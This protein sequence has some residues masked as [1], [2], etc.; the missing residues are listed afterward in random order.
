MRLSWVLLPLLAAAS[1]AACNPNK[2]NEAEGTR[3]SEVSS[4]APSASAAEA[5]KEKPK[6]ATLQGGVVARALTHD[7]IYVADEDMGVLHEVIL[8]IGG[9][10]PPRMIDVPGQPANMVALGDSVLV[11]I[12]SEGAIPPGKDLT[13]EEKAKADAPPEPS[14]SAAPVKAAPKSTAKERY[15]RPKM[16]PIATGAGLLLVMKRDAEKGLVITKKIELPEDAWGLAVTP[17]EATA[18]VTSAWTHQVSGVEMA[19]GKVKFTLDVGREPRGI[20]I[21][22]NGK[23]AY[24]THLVGTA[25]TRI[26][27]I[28]GEAPTTKSI[29]LP[30]SRLRTP[31]LKKSSASL[32][33]SATLSPDGRKLYVARHA[34]GA[35][36]PQAWNGVATVDVLLTKDDT[37]LAP[38]RTDKPNAIGPGWDAESV[39]NDP[40]TGAGG[41][42]MSANTFAQPRAIVYSKRKDTVLVVSEGTEGILAFPGKPLDPSMYLDNS[43]DLGTDRDEKTG[44]SRACEAPS[45]IV[46]SEDEKRGWVFCRATGTLVEVQ[47][48]GGREKP[49]IKLREDP[50]P[51]LAALGR[52]LFYNGTDPLLSGGMGCAG[53]HPEG[54]DDG[55]VWHEADGASTNRNF[56]AGSDNVPIWDQEKLAGGGYPRQTP[57]LAGRVAAEGPYGWHAESPYL[58]H[59]LTSSMFLHRWGDI[60]YGHDKKELYDRAMALRAFLRLG[61]V[62]PPKRAHELTEEEKK[63]QEIFLRVD[64]K[65]AGCHVPETDYS[66]R[67]AYPIYAKL[68]PP[69]GYDQDPEPKYK[70]PSLLFVGGTA[71]YTHDGR[72]STLEQVIDWNEDRMGNTKQLT[73]PE[74][75][76]LVAYLRTL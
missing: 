11:T 64:T 75:A 42:R 20:A 32:A 45:G 37:P 3:P 44:L 33:Y 56:F 6:P 9:T 38:P 39:L 68:D 46:L 63:G 65:C 61:L 2:N 5:P 26:D 16:V 47:L 52:K 51:A 30:A 62:P 43:L 71:P 58:A 41:P 12:R 14:A 70:T 74:R 4:A 35:T 17:D 50:L 8:P 49:W 60:P 36:G 31:Q 18:L 67:A 76:A 22:P 10:T 21:H 72:F 29:D 54:R 13:A 7:A 66:D 19:T 27:G 48:T 57:M 23:T 34:L 24:V 28:D 69:K 25:L 15:V 40:N 59:R 55:H 53:C 73:K 1:A